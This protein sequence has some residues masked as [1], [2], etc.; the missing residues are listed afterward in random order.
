[1]GG[2][3]KRTPVPTRINSREGRGWGGRGGGLQKRTPVPFNMLKEK[4]FLKNLLCLKP[5]S[6]RITYQ[7]PLVSVLFV[8]MT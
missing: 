6:Q 8:T 4:Y 7:I 3:K 1:M 5:F 2:L